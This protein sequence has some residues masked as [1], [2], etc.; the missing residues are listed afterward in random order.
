MIDDSFLSL[1]VE[2]RRR[3][4]LHVIEKE[5]GNIKSENSFCFLRETNF[6]Y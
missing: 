1:K 3:I 4:E 2:D 6:H 5:E